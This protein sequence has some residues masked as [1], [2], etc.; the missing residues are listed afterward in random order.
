[1]VWKNFLN[2]EILNGLMKNRRRDG[3]VITGSFN[4]K[5]NILPGLHM[6]VITDVS[7]AAI[8]FSASIPVISRKKTLST[9]PT[10]TT[11]RH[12]WHCF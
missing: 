4:S 12:C 3:T 9:V 1:M 8:R 11:R 6:C 10:P 5:S 2:G 7:E